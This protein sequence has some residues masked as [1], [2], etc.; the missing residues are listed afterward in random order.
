[1]NALTIYIVSC[2]FFIA[3]AME[4]Y[5]ILLYVSRLRLD[6]KVDT[7]ESE[8]DEKGDKI[9]LVI[10]VIAF[11][12]PVVPRETARIRTQM[13]AAHTPE[14]IDQAIA[15]FTKVGKALGVIK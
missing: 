6:S 10:Y 9:M 8:K 4:Q 2:M 7:E 12:F 11:T 1:M 14:Q 13:S 15:A 5:G 3:I